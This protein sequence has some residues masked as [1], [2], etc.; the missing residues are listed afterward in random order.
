MVGVKAAGGSMTYQERQKYLLEHIKFRMANTDRMQHIVTIVE[1]YYDVSIRSGVLPEGILISIPL[2]GFVQTRAQTNCEISTMQL[3]FP[4]SW[5][6][7]P[8]CLSSNQGFK[9]N[10]GPGYAVRLCMTV[11]FVNINSV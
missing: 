7:V 3:W 4:A 6:P 1:A 2:L 9:D 11:E 8:G 10:L 5:A